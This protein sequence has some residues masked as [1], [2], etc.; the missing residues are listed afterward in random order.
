MQNPN[1][2]PETWVCWAGV[3]TLHRSHELHAFGGEEPLPTQTQPWAWNSPAAS[4]LQGGPA[5]LP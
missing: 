2:V 4:T 1:S 3:S 5:D